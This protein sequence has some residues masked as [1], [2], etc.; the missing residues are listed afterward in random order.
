MSFTRDTSARRLKIA[1]LGATILS[2]LAIG[3]TAAHAQTAAP[4]ATAPAT[5]DSTVVVVT[6]YRGSLQ[7][8][9]QA[10]KRAVGFED[11]IFAEDIGKFPDTNIAESFNRIPGIV[12]SRDI[13]GDGVNVSIRG[14]G[15]SFTRVL[16]NGAPVAVAST[17]STDSQNTNREV[18]L[19]LFPTELFTQ[20][21]VDK[22]PQASMVEG[23]AAGTVNMRQARPFDH[24]G[25]LLSY[26]FDGTK[27]SNDAK[28]G[29]KASLLGSK[30]WDH[31]GVLGGITVTDQQVANKGFETIGWTNAG[32]TFQQCGDT[33]TGSLTATST[34]PA[35]NTTG[36]GNWS[37]PNTVPANTGNSS[38]VTGAT[39]TPAL[40][41]S[42]NPG[43]SLAQISN[44]I[45]PRL[46]RPMNEYGTRDRVSGVFG[47][48]WRPND[49]FHAYLD[50]MYAYK[51]NKMQRTDMDWV[52]RNG[53]MIPVNMKV[54]NTSCTNGCVV[55]DATFLNS[56][57][58][59]EYRPY[60][61]TTQFTGINPGFDWKLNDRLTLSGSANYTRST[62]H[63]E[64]PSFLVITAPSS[65]LTV[66]YHNG[67]DIPTMSS[68][69]DL[70]NPANF[71]WNGGRVNIQDE[72]RITET[73]GVRG[74]LKWGDSQF[75][76]QVG[77][78]YDD[79]SRSITA[80]D[81]SQAWQN[82]VCGDNPSIYVPGPNSQ[83]A[84][85]G[86]NLT[87]AAALA[88]GYPA[89]PGLGTGYTSGNTTPLTYAGSLVPNLALAQYLAPGPNG[90][91]TVNW[92]A[93]AAA[94]KYQQF[95]D[96]APLAT[97]SNT[98][99]SGGFVEEKVQGAYIQV[100][101]DRDIFGNRLR[102]NA[103][104]RAITTDQTIGG[105]VSIPDPRNTPPAPAV[106]PADGG[107]YPNTV[108]F[109]ETKS[110]YKDYLPSFNAAYSLTDKLLARLSLSTT[111]TRANP[112]SELPGLNFSSPSA[113]TGT[114][115]NPDLKPYISKNTDFGLEY[116]TGKEGYLSAT[117][118][119]KNITGFTAN[120]NST[121]PFSSLA[122]YGVTYDALTPTQQAAI[123][124]RGG[125]SNANVVLTEQVNASGLL[126]I[127]G[128]ELNWVQPL[129][130]WWAPLAGFGYST[131]ATY[132]HQTGTGA[133]PAIAT[134]VPKMTYNV[135][136]YYEGHGL[137]IHL[138]DNYNGG[139]QASGANQNGI[140]A[141]A[142]FNDSRSQIDLSS[143]YDLGSWGIAKNTQITLDATNITN[144]K[145]RQYFQFKNATFTEY[146]PG[147]TVMVGIRGKF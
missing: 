84:C 133:A 120:G 31:W 49:D 99:A 7:S 132:I 116:Y 54:D 146:Q 39:I 2:G 26:S 16:L 107:K 29:D 135:T 95:H 131:N 98:G 117:Y 88:A 91:I 90:Y 87:T 64:S 70:N 41:Q 27:S 145:I 122:A 82:A 85:K 51:K 136:L 56:Q 80:F 128:L 101:G 109:V 67:G 34:D 125:P 114:V 119:H 72:K 48:E 19:D 30:T 118:F 46:G 69:V 137:S 110:T 33:P 71:Q 9:T 15:T 61:E 3:A 93:F 142:F 113:D 40:L 126:K 79:T 24:K 129:E 81:N 59:L 144:T 42:L 5:D 8:S 65:G 100:N 94:S 22:S 32:L 141:A 57:F 104:I 6:G 20:L 17:G 63:R 37:I 14:L 106:A 147:S 13:N 123:N 139:S 92:P 50:T 68:N 86:D 28:W 83:P 66:T 47:L 121:V 12:I 111:M 75:N 143:S 134:G 21:T 138:S 1:L 127:N 77:A 76:I 55:T 35:C 53:S 130:Q 73:K 89:Y 62:F 18:D 10:K 102:W 74:D 124:A 97:A 96:A 108:K 23:G 43:L 58:F 38:L 115:G 60:T 45:I 78:S 44:A 140:T 103:G 36:G 4:A 52:G 25:E 112:N 105:Y 11:A